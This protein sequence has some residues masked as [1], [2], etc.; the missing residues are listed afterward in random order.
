LIGDNKAPAAVSK[1]GRVVVISG[2]NTT[3]VDTCAGVSGCTPSSA[4]I[5]SEPVAGIS[6]DGR[7]VFVGQSLYE[8]C[9]GATSGCFPSPTQSLGGVIMRF[10]GDARFAVVSDGTALLYK[11]TCTGAPVGCSTSSSTIE[12]PITANPAST[13][14]RYGLKYYEG[15]HYTGDLHL[16]DTC[17][18]ATGCTPQDILISE[19][20]DGSHGYIPYLQ[21]DGFVS[22]DSARFVAF[23]SI[24]PNVTA[25]DTNEVTDVFVRDTCTGAPAGCTPRT[26]RLNVG[27]NGAQANGFSRVL[28]MSRSG[29]FILV[30][31]IASNLGADGEPPANLYMFRNPLY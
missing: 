1:G 11:D 12:T 27:P 17:F 6:D 4:T 24:S 30:F 22:N 5:P 7:Y 18:G 20:T 16:R 8:T 10:T 15:S 31:T 9:I 29:E 14:G 26:V 25:N 21:W 23:T 13:D 3:V 19:T 2:V 28:Q